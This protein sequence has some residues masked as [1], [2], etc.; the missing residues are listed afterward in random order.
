MTDPP[1]QRESR[2]EENL[3]AATRL[4]TATPS[5]TADE[6]HRLDTRIR[7]LSRTIGNN[8]T[9]LTDLI[10]QAKD[11]EIHL[12]LGFPSW[13]AYL[14]SALGELE[15]A[16]NAPARRELV[17]LLSDEGMSN[18][19]I[20]QAVGVTEG[21]VRNDKVRNDYAPRRPTIAVD[22]TVI[23][24]ATG[25]VI[26]EAPQRPPVTGLDG[27]AYPPRPKPQPP[28]EGQ[29]IAHHETE[30]LVAEQ[31]TLNRWSRAV[32][33]LTNALSY[34]KTFTP[35]AIPANH[36]SIQEFKTRLAALVEISNQ[37]A[38]PIGPRVS[39]SA[40]LRFPIVD[41]ELVEP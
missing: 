24:I 4:T 17:A 25:E 40:T 31:E 39:D 3:E 15:L 22:R 23:D 35:P 2:P 28:T 9:K 7:L 8:L 34:A 20:A 32:D 11:T 27:K 18:R 38:D 26:S 16:M 5:L 6:A 30:K 19:A 14:A 1:K 21:T 10:G 13:T 36:V 37:W 29:L 33:G 41:A 12:V